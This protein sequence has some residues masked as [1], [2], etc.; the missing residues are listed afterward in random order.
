MLNFSASEIEE[1]GGT[2][3]EF[4]TS[5]SGGIRSWTEK[6]TAV[7]LTFNVEYTWLLYMWTHM[8]MLTVHVC[9][10][11]YVYIYMRMYIHIHVHIYFFRISRQ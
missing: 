5:C 9:V 3:V 1:Q 2:I 8:S 11:T 7:E 6:K 10:C 4:G